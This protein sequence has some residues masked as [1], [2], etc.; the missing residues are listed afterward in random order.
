LVFL[1]DSPTDRRQT[2]PPAEELDLSG[3][4]YDLRTL[5]A[6]TLSGWLLQTFV[7][8]VVDS[9][10][11]LLVAPSVRRPHPQLDESPTYWPTLTPHPA[12]ARK[13]FPKR[14]K[15]AL[16]PLS[17]H[18]HFISYLV[19]GG[20]LSVGEVTGYRSTVACELPIN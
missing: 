18:I 11:W 2:L 8:L 14:C 9:P 3:A 19:R 1:S 6:P 5:R 16:H 13:T 7:S 12:T 10:L 15:S 4:V 20:L 17:A